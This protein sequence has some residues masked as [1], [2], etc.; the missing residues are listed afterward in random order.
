MLIDLAKI[1]N[2]VENIF[3]TPSVKWSIQNSTMYKSKSKPQKSEC[4]M[5]WQPL[6]KFSKSEKISDVENGV[7]CDNNY[8][9]YWLKQV[10]FFK[11]HL[12]KH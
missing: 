1:I 4:K 3:R 5:E 9:F 7:F 8:P 10:N 6:P 2:S 11:S 12:F